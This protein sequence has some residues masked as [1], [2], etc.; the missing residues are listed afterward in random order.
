MRSLLAAATSKDHAP[1]QGILAR[2]GAR[3]DVAMD[4][5]ATR[6]LGSALLL[7]APSRE[8]GPRGLVRRVEAEDRAAGADLMEFSP[9]PEKP[10]IFR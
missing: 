1:R 2:C 6:R 5:S 7:G 3:S 10:G 4:Q 8:F 9:E